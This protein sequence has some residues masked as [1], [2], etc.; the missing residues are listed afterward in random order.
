MSLRAHSV[1]KESTQALLLFPYRADARAVTFGF[2]D[3]SR[4]AESC[5]GQEP[6]HLIPAIKVVHAGLG[7]FELADIL[8]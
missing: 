1:S 2:G 4:L 3:E 6:R 5:L 7:D 8:F